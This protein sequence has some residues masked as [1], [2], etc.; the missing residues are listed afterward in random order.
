[1][2]PS[3]EFLSF[4]RWLSSSCW[5]QYCG[6]ELK[7]EYILCGR[8]CNIES[9]ELCQARVEEKN[10]T[11]RLY[12]CVFFYPQVIGIKYHKEA[13]KVRPWCAKLRKISVQPPGSH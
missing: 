12:V 2:T 6:L 11:R 4:I 13:E 9:V 8:K 5:S 7:S 10:E 3:R 1:M